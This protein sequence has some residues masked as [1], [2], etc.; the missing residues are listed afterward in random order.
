MFR[1]FGLFFAYPFTTITYTFIMG[2]NHIFLRRGSYYESEVSPMD[3]SATGII[4]GCSYRMSGC[5]WS[6]RWQ[7]NG[8]WCEYQVR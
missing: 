2:M 3:G 5:G 7:S 8:Q 1:P 4:N 6:R